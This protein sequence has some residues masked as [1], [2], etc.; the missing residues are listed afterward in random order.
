M[1][2]DFEGRNIRKHVDTMAE[3]RSGKYSSRRNI[4]LSTKLD[5]DCTTFVTLKFSF[6]KILIKI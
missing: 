6:K 1:T 2:L 5:D 4:E 3:V